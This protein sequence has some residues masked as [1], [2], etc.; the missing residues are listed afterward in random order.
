MENIN[1]ETNC[2]YAFYIPET[3]EIIAHPNNL[4]LLYKA[5][6]RHWKNEGLNGIFYTNNKPFAKLENG[7]IFII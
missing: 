4:K 6:V 1:T 7:T 5:A 2:K 3:L